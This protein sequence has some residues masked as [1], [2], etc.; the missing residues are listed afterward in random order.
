[1]VI[2]KLFSLI[3]PV[4]NSGAKI[5]RTIESVLSQKPELFDYIIV[6]GKSTDDTVAAIG[7]YKNEVTFIS[8]SDRGI[9]DAMNKGIERASGKYLYFLGAGDSLKP[10]VLESIAPLLP[11][12]GPAFVYGNVFWEDSGLVYAGKFGKAKL[13]KQNICHQAIFYERRIFDLIGKYELR[14]KVLAD[15]VLNIKCFGNNQIK[16]HYLD[17]IIANFEGG[18]FSLKTPDEAFDRERAELFETYLKE[19]SPD[20]QQA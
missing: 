18:G 10:D 4:F 2:P 9:Y 6:D 7:P 12:S 15:W 1:M 11:I 5:Q 3:T 20:A 13:R 19:N 14:F 17:E 8:E 16:K